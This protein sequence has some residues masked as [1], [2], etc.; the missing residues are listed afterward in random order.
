MLVPPGTFLTGSVVLKDRVDLHLSEDATLL[1]SPWMRDY[2]ARTLR[3]R[4]R[5]G[6]D[7]LTSLVFAQG[8]N[9]VS[10]SGKGILDGNSRGENDFISKDRIEKHRPGLVWFDECS[11]APMYEHPVQF[12]EAMLA[13]A[14][15][16][17]R[18]EGRV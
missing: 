15:E 10:V 1:G 11:H 2:P 12:G 8:A 14:D 16:L 13:F 7:L 18:R 3:S 4:C 9:A 5:Y 6:R 17:D